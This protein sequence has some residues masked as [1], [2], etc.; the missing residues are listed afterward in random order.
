MDTP[1]VVVPLPT[2]M[3]AGGLIC[4]RGVLSGDEHKDLTDSASWKLTKTC[5]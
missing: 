3:Y 1:K 2:E 5:R 4:G